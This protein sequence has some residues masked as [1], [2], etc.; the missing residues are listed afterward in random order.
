[1]PVR[2]LCGVSCHP[3]VDMT[4]N[5]VSRFDLT[6][7]PVRETWMSLEG[8]CGSTVPP[9]G[10]TLVLN[11]HFTSACFATADGPMRSFLLLGQTI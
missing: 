6:L 3:L 5:Q 4:K 7:V 11:H 9:L 10:N 1:M 8:A 2:A